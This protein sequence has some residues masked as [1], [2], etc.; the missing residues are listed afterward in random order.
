MPIDKQRGKICGA[1]RFSKRAGCVP[2]SARSAKL[3]A[4]AV[5]SWKS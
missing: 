2:S 3:G 1:A 5:I 4:A